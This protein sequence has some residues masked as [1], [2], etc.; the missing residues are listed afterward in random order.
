M[1]THKVKVNYLFGLPRTVSDG[2]VNIDV[3]RNVNSVYSPTQ[4][5]ERIKAFMILSGLSSSGWENKILETY[6]NVPSVSSVR[7][8]K[9]AS[10]QGIPIYTINNTNLN[11]I[12]PQLQV[13]GDVLADI[14]NATNAG[15]EVIVSKTTISSGQWHGLG[16]IIIDPITGAA[17]YQISGGLA[18]GAANPNP[19]LTQSQKSFY[20]AWATVYTRMAALILA[21]AYL[22]TPYVYGSADPDCGFDCSGFVYFIFISVYGDKAFGNQRLWTVAAQHDFLKSKGWTYPYAERLP[23]DI[24]WKSNYKHTGINYGL[25]YVIHASGAP[26]RPQSDPNGWLPPA[27]CIVPGTEGSEVICGEFRRVVITS[28]DGWAVASEIGRPTPY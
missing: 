26:C 23:G 18:G 25:G 19:P 28:I 6:F 2:G 10:E 22:G 4:D 7:L 17:S 8:L 13:D 14:V 16:Y 24:V 11:D 3:D 21:T 15:K 9:L 20:S 27:Q 12:I 1:V 5:A